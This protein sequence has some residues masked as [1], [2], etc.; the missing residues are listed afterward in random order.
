MEFIQ[1]LNELNAVTNDPYRVLKGITIG[2]IHLS[3]Q[4]S[5][6]HYCSPR[7]TTKLE[8]YYDM[9]LAII[10]NIEGE[11]VWINVENDEVFSDFSKIEEFKERNS[12]QGLYAFLSVSLIEELYQYLQGKEKS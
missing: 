7:I 8:N 12:T 9:E 6:G 10:K 4:G 1:K 2:D 3:I 11:G 5:S